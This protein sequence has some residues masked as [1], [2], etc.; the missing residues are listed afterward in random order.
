MTRLRFTIWAI[1][2]IALCLVYIAFGL[3]HFRWQYTWLNEG[4]GHDPLAQ[5]HYL[6]CTFWGPYGRFT[7]NHPAR[8]EC[9]WIMF[10]KSS[11]T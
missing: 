2:P 8:G 5:R 3:P 6:S 1:V 9:D 4:Q 10:K 7:V 11:D